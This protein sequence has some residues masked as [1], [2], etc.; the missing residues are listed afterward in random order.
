MRRTKSAKKVMLNKRG[1]KTRRNLHL[2]KSMCGVMT[3]E[4]SLALVGSTEI[5]SL[6]LNCLKYAALES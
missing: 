4:G 5:I 1:K 6:T 3:P 2:T